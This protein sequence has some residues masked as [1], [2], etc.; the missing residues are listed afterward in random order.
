MVTKDVNE[1]RLNVYLNDEGV[2]TQRRPR[3]VRHAGL[4]CRLASGLVETDGA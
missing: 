4:A 3:L 2:V 1:N